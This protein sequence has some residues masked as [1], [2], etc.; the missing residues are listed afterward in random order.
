MVIKPWKDEITS[1]CNK[2]R[3]VIIISINQTKIL[4]VLWS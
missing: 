1:K 2:I 4:F 3:K